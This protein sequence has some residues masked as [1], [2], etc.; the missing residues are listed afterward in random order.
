MQL[1]SEQISNVSVSIQASHWRQTFGH[2]IHT[3]HWRQTFG[4]NI[5]YQ[6][7]KKGCLV[8]FIIQ[9]VLQ[10]LTKLMS[11]MTTYFQDLKVFAQQ[12]QKSREEFA[13]C[14]AFLRS[15]TFEKAAELTK[16][17]KLRVSGWYFP[18]TPHL[19]EIA[20]HNLI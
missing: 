9:V 4:H 8:F 16:N 12:C 2:N 14:E 13:S 20:L 3:S 5:Q 7:S 18:I 1:R 17:F 11:L 15:C 6:L 10:K 19:W